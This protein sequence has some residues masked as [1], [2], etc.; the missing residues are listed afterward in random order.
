MAS[1]GSFHT[2]KSCIGVEGRWIHH[3]DHDA[4]VERFAKYDEKIREHMS[5][6]EYSPFEIN[7]KPAPICTAVTIIYQQPVQ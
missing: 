5:E 1:S 3:F 7:G 2:A 4:A 6:W